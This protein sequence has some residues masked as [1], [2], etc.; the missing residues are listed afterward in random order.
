MAL[1]SKSTDPNLSIGDIYMTLNNRHS[2]AAGQTQLQIPPF[3]NR[4]SRERRSIFSQADIVRRFGNNIGEYMNK[5]QYQK[6]AQ[7]VGD[8][9]MAN[10]LE[11]ELD[12]DREIEMFKSIYQQ[13]SRLGIRMDDRF[14]DN[15]CLVISKDSRFL[16]MWNSTQVKIVDVVKGSCCSNFTRTCRYSRC[17][18]ITRFKPCCRC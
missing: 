11:L 8:F 15:S 16:A 12:M 3:S 10:K 1:N 5:Q 18:L 13:E 4:H 2:S 9:L 17:I 7:E 6:Y 14:S